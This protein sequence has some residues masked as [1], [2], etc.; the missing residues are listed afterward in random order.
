MILTSPLYLLFLL[1]LPALWWLI[2]ALPPRPKEQIFPPTFLL[3]QLRPQQNDAANIPLWLLI[4]RICALTCLIITFSG[5]VILPA[6]QKDISGQKLVLIVDNGWASYAHWNDR[7]KSLQAL[8]ESSIRS[9]GHVTILLTARNENGEWPTP[10]T[11]MQQ[12]ELQTFLLKIHPQ[13]WS[14]DRL[15]L[16]QHLSSPEM[17]ALLHNAHVIFLSDSL[18]EGHEDALDAPLSLAD[19][20]EDIRWPSCD[21]I[22]LRPLPKTKNEKFIA[23][24]L[25]GCASIPISLQGLN[26]S[27]NGH[28]NT[29]YHWNAQTNRPFKASLP[30]ELSLPLNALKIEHIPAPE[31]IYLLNATQNQASIGLIHLTGDNE[32]LTGSAFY[33]ARAIKNFNT[34]Q[35]NDLPHLLKESL[36]LLIAPDG[37][38]TDKNKKDILE[39]VQKGG[40]LLRFSGPLLAQENIADDINAQENLIPVPLLHG[41]RQLG[42]AMSWGKAQKLARFSSSSPFSGLN[43]P[44]DI[45]ISKQILA[46]PSNDLEE[47][48]WAELEDGTPLITARQEG[49]GM[50]VL[51]H[52]TPTANW[53]NLVL[54]ELFPE[55]LERLSQRA[56]LLAHHSEDE[57]TMSFNNFPAWRILDHNAALHLP[58]STL[59]PLPA[60]AH[61][62]TLSPFL[63]AGY[64][65]TQTQRI[66]LNLTSSSAPH[67]QIEPLLGSARTPEHLQ[68]EYPLGPL[69]TEIA[70]ALLLID[71]VLSLKRAGALSRFLKQNTM[72]MIIAGT[73]FY[74]FSSPLWAATSEISTG[75]IPNNVPVSSLETKLAYISSPNAETNHILQEGLDGLSQFIN[76]RSTTHLGKSVPVIL[77]KDMLVFYPVLYWA[78]EPDTSLTPSQS[79]ALNDYMKHG[80]LLIIDKMGANSLLDGENGTATQ[81][82][83][84][85]AS[86]NL[87]IPPLKEITDQDV[88][89]HS[90]YLLKHFPGRIDGQKTYITR[91]GNDD[92]DD[93]SP[94]IIGN[95]DWA[96][97]WAVDQNGEHP[98]AVLPGG[99]EQRMLAYR[100]G[101]NIVIYALTGN[102]KNDQKRYPEMLKR[103]KNMQD[104][105]AT[106]NGEMETV[107][108]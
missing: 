101:M 41:Q 67:L 99:E 66:P 69:M 53:S 4:L 32:P 62:I 83:L 63:Q 6:Q 21:I 24:T 29:I 38:I 9:H 51:F 98:F 18:K 100:T 49:A 15:A 76:Q 13:N 54:S 74:G 30:H 1:L 82:A 104:D 87:D 77:G 55:M 58:S 46:Q 27:P 10:I 103:L 73:L 11:P 17:T 72:M 39:W 5:P 45:T 84:E 68:I 88:L 102:Y 42:G 97:A 107:E 60:K 48:V 34:L 3:S 33:L 22:T 80:G 52:I 50:I 40:M 90:F 36:S 94:V 105:S 85:K 37:T 93:V 89:S 106:E 44:Q 65:G 20:V 70:L 78:I 75:N 26:L 16:A 59:T 8:A 86:Q 61:L 12:E 96:H 64:Y 28:F 2:R 95:S 91:S 31:G 92:G 14:V 23:E 81:E 7:L 79:D 19:N 56:A 71:G 43:I 25:P 47:H 57:E 35:I 108:P